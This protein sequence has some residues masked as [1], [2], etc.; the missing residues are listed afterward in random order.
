MFFVPC[1]YSSV[2]SD[3]YCFFLLSESLKYVKE[4]LLCEDMGN[5]GRMPNCELYQDCSK[6]TFYLVGVLM[7]Y[8]ICLNGPAP[9][10]FSS[11][12]YEYIVGGQEAVLQKLPLKLQ[13]STNLSHAYNK[14]KVSEKHLVT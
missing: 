6:G 12:L 14:V 11:W 5:D 4:N 1:I 8:S 7:A 10:F 2:F 9:N 13:D 3:A